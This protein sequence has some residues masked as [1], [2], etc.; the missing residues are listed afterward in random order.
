MNVGGVSKCCRLLCM[1]MRGAWK[2]CTYVYCCT[3]VWVGLRSV[4]NLTTSPYMYIMSFIPK[5]AI[6]KTHRNVHTY[7][8][9]MNIH[10]RMCI[11]VYSVCA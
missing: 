10:V 11:L 5:N 4:V 8:A 9:G 2:G 1:N 7:N 6:L 3:G